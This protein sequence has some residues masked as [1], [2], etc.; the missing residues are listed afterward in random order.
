MG[1]SVKQVENTYKQ[2]VKHKQD[3]VMFFNIKPPVV[4]D[5]EEFQNSFNDEDVVTIEDAVVKPTVAS[6]SSTMVI[7]F[8]AA[9]GMLAQ[10]LP[11]VQLP[12]S[13]AGHIIEAGPMACVAPLN[14]TL[15]VSVPLKVVSA[16]E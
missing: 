10:E 13:S 4:L 16:L 9:A 12:F 3:A 1:N 15:N 6:C 7:I 11:P 8:S 5:D 2:L 14:V